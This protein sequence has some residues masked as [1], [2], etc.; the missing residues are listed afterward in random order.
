ML[1]LRAGGTVL[2]TVL[3]ATPA[4]AVPVG[5]LQSLDVEVLQGGNTLYS[6]T[7]INTVGQIDGQ[8]ILLGAFE[9]NNVYLSVTLDQTSVP[10]VEDRWMA[11]K[12]IGKTAGGDPA[13]L[14]RPTDDGEITIRLTNMQYSN[15]TAGG[16]DRVA[17]FYP[18]YY[19]PYPLTQLPFFYLLDGYRGFVNLPASQKYSPG[20]PAPYDLG[21]LAP[22]S[23]QVPFS[24]WTAANGYGFAQVDNGLT[25]GFELSG[26]ADFGGTGPTN[27]NP[28]DI[29]PG[30]WPPVPPEYFGTTFT[31]A[32]GERGFVSE[33]GIALNMLGY[34]VPE[35][36]TVWLL[37]SAGMLL[38]RRR[39]VAR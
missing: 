27:D 13:N 5:L 9:G 37:L 12:V 34:Q 36:A 11:V 31:P 1:S 20:E 39:T 4:F 16:L 35:P 25:T 32:P 29:T 24:A 38:W 19:V 14:F 33:I 2:L 17:P 6:F 30:L 23:V 22:T 3:L 26:V 28:L 15:V 10:L 18:S 8:E 21:G 7:G